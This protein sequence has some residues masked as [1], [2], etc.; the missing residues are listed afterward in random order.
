MANSSFLTTFTRHRDPKL[1]WPLA[2]MASVL[3]HGLGLGLVRTLA[4]QTP[5][6]PDGAMA[7]L[8]IQ[9]VTLPPDRASPGAE[10]PVDPS[11]DPSPD[12]MDL[13]S[14]P[15]TPFAPQTA[16][17]DLE[18]PAPVEPA[19]ARSPAPVPLTAS[20][21]VAPAPRPTPAPA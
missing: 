19:P 3:A 8:P 15:P 12:P 7:P 2:A 14:D 20:P 11:A 10:W 17:P 5:A 13:V 4:I 21:P 6:L 9:L 18:I 16:T 1:L